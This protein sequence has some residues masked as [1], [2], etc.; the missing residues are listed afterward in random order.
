MAWEVGGGWLVLHEWG[1]DPRYINAHWS[2]EL[3]GLLLEKLGKRRTS[4]LR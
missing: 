2:E 1:L 4:G 3:F